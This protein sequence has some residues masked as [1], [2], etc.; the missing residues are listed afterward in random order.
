MGG[1]PVI[2]VS[3]LQTILAESC[4]RISEASSQL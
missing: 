1:E 2:L 3:S 4:L